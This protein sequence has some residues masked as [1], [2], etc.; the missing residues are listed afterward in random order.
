M[1][2]VLL[3][4]TEVFA[5]VSS[6]RPIVFGFANTGKYLAV[7]FDVVDEAPLSVYPVTAYETEP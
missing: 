5:S 6:G 4:A 1:E 2:D 7:V 3:G